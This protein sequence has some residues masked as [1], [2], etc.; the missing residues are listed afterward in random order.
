MWMK[1]MLAKAFCLYKVSIEPYS[2]ITL[3]LLDQDKKQNNIFAQGTIVLIVFCI[4]SIYAMQTTHFKISWNQLEHSCVISN[5]L[6]VLSYSNTIQL[7]DLEKLER[8]VISNTE[9]TL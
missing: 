5:K 3:R 4:R 7:T 6:F 8:N 9:I 2:L 1:W